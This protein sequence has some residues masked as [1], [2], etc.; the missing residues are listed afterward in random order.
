MREIVVLLDG[1]RAFEDLKDRE[2]VTGEIQRFVIL[3]G[4]MASGKPSC[5]WLVELPAGGLV[6]AQLSV[7][8]FQKI[9]GAVRGKYGEVS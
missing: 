7:A 8:M 5:A 3:D 4:G 9:A 2:I 6:Y 1:D